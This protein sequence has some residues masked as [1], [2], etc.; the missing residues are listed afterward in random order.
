M[1]FYLTSM[2]YLAIMLYTVYLGGLLGGVWALW[3]THRKQRLWGILL[4]LE[5]VA[6]A[7]LLTIMSSKYWFTGSEGIISIAIEPLVQ[8]VLSISLP[9]ILGV[10]IVMGIAYLATRLIR[11]GYSR[12]GPLLPCLFIPLIFAAST[13]QLITLTERSK[14]AVKDTPQE[15]TIA[16]GFEISSFK[17][18]PAHNPTSIAF[19]PDGNLYIANY[20]GDIWG[21]SMKDGKSWQYAT[22][23]R[24]PVGLT[25]HDQSLYVASYGT[26]S[27]IHDKNQDHVGDSV[28]DIITDLPAR[29]YPWHA[30]N[31]I[32]FGSDD[33]MYFAVGATSDSSV[34]TRQYAASIVSAKADGSDL[35][36]F[37]TGVRN[38]Y[39]LAFNSKGDLFATDNG[40]DALESTPPDELNHIVEGGNYGFPTEFGIPAPGSD[41]QGPIALFPPHASADGL[42]F[43]QGDKFPEQYFDNAFVTLWHM[44]QIYRVQFNQDAKGNYTTRLSLFVTGLV[45][46]LDTAVGPDGNLY[47]IDFNTSTIYKIQYVGGD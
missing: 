19:G 13:R 40:P 22:G 32:A 39:R 12:I 46:P 5:S 30:N 4:F 27:I 29:V 24:V 1:L 28:E 18:E 2:D 14:S 42:V 33:R 35:S 47:V 10:A 9:L 20:N 8:G 6:A 3:K 15:I 38:P 26:V 41:V 25:W 7:F 43:Y 34:E 16:P 44:G 11:N 45:S 31:G 21:I 36:V 17:V 37:A 23:L